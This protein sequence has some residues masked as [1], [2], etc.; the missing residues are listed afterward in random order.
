LTATAASSSSITL[1][2]TAATDNVGVTG[3]KVYR[4]GSSIASPTGTSYTDSGLTAST[5]YSYYVTAHDASGNQSAHSN[6]ASATTPSSSA[7]SNTYIGAHRTMSTSS[8]NNHDLW[9]QASNDVGPWT[10]DR[11]FQTSMTD[12]AY[13]PD[14]T[15]VPAMMWP[16]FACNGDGQWRDIANGVYDAN[17]QTWANQQQTNRTTYL[18]LDHEWERKVTATQTTDD[19]KAMHKHVHN[20]LSSWPKIKLVVI[21]SSYS[22]KPTN[23]QGFDPSTAQPD[24]ADV[25]GYSADVYWSN[26]DG[27]PDLMV[28]KASYSRWYNWAKQTGKPLHCTEW[29]YDYVQDQY[30]D[31]PANTRGNAIAAQGQWFID[32]GFETAQY[33]DCDSGSGGVGGTAHWYV[34]G[35]TPAEQAMRDLSAKGRPL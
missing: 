32:Q 14:L 31:A 35:D 4:G 11:V 9:V 34:D 13:T 22:W 25:D 16:S 12:Y 33:W 7:Q 6:T 3:Y 2:W 29:A 5:A 24:P 20:L 10:V 26:S 28:T 17:L 21:S 19:F 18:T 15:D 1:T 8:L 23:P 27:L 30:P